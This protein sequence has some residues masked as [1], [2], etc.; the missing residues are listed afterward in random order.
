MPDTK[1]HS[2][3]VEMFR[4]SSDINLSQQGREEAHE[5]A[6]ATR[7]AEAAMQGR[8]SMM[9]ACKNAFPSF[10]FVMNMACLSSYKPQRRQIFA[11]ALIDAGEVVDLICV[12]VIGSAAG[13]IL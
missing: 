3:S 4:G 2:G 11:N 8:L 7:A 12:E 13:A 1:H 10:L 9:M 6:K 5:V